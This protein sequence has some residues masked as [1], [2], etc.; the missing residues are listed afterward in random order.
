[1]TDN[2]TA[3]WRI[4]SAQVPTLYA[5]AETLIEARRRAMDRLQVA[6]VDLDDMRYEMVDLWA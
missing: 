1:M 5:S 6:G 3:F 4:D 2:T